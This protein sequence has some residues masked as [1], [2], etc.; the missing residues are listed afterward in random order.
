METI[1]IIPAR[2]GSSRFPGKVL[3]DLL[4]RPMIQ[5][6]WEA[7]KRTHCLE[8]LIVA[9]DEE[10]VVRAVE[11][12]GGKAILTSRDHRS[13]TDRIVEVVAALKVKVVIN[14]QGDEPMLEPSMVD[15]LAKLMLDDPDIGMATLMHSISDPEELEDPNVVKVVTDKDGF[16]LY[17]S[18]APIPYWK[19][20]H[21]RAFKHIGMYAY[22]KD[23]LLKFAKLPS[24]ALEQQEAL[25]QLRALECGFR[26][27]V[28]ETKHNP[29]GV[30]TPA[31]LEKVK[32][33]LSK[34]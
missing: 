29:V 8:D 1:G 34:R 33:L 16:A 4:G 17:F 2:L 30:D 10:R 24:T 25:E 15:D 3:A 27:K 28:I 9:T 32:G 6:V 19:I 12:F 22:T 21:Q 31:D 11:S 13:G 14:I 7:A 23:F 5:W 26:I 20:S 18:R